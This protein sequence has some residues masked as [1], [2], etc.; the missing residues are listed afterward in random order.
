M[1]QLQP[2]LKEAVQAEIAYAKDEKTRQEKCS[3]VELR[4][5]GLS[6]FPLDCKKV[7]DN[8]VSTILHLKASFHINDQFF[9]NGCK[10]VLHVNDQ[11]ITGRLA[12]LD[13]TEMEVRIDEETDFNPHDFS[14]RVDFQP[15]DVTFKCM[16]LGIQFLETKPHLQAFEEELKTEPKSDFIP[17]ENPKL[18]TNQQLAVSAILSDRKTVCIQG[19]PGTGKTTTLVQ[20]IL[21]LVAD[22]KQVIIC[23]PSNTAVDNIC[24][25]LLEEKTG[26]LRLG[27]DEKIHPLV[28]PFTS[29]GHLLRTQGKAIE[30]LQKSIQKAVQVATRSIRNFTPEA[31]QEKRGAQ[32]DLR[33][34]RSEIRTMRKQIFQQLIESIPVIAGTPVSLFNHLP[35]EKISDIVIMDEA[36]Q[37]MSPLAWL[38]ASFGKRLV[39]CGDPQQLPPTVFS[40]KAREL[41]VSLLEAACSA[42]EP[43]LLN[44]QY[45]MGEEIVGA[46]NPFFYRNQLQTA[47]GISPAS[48]YFI[49]MAGYGEGEQ[50]DE[51]TGSTYNLSE[52][53][54]LQKMLDH[55]HVR[56]SETVILSPYSAQLDEIRKVIESGWRISTIDS[57]QGQEAV[58]CFISLTRSNEEQQ[59]GFLSDYRRTNVAISRAKELCVLIGDSSTLGNDKFYNDLISYTE[60]IGNYKS[61]YEFL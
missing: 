57:I 19:P 14:F 30:H 53:E 60:E 56:A 58:N 31:K 39:L 42:Q 40:P 24:L 5:M 44:T 11:I 7:T 8:G 2:K 32:Q 23:A 18:N 4:A 55:F 3:P 13:G 47:V 20:S 46:I 52:I 35:K 38:A 61:A 45:R 27:N 1:S 51:I 17:L 49:D 9:Y 10:L 59:I 26:I 21:K 29:E 50:K 25:K 37:C 15:D 36:G 12:A 28:L 33:Q 34:M 16:E 54:I 41:T 43:Y 48:L 6:I 22:K